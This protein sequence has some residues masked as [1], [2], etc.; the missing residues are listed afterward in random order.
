MHKEKTHWAGIGYD[1]VIGNGTDSG[2]G[3]I[4][5]TFR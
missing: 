5:V 2:D 1:F 3:E 4:E